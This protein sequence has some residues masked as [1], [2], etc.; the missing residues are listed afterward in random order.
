[1]KFGDAKICYTAIFRNEEKNVY[2]CLDAL[3]DMIDFVCITD[4]GSEDDT[5]KLIQ[6]WGRENDKPTKVFK[7]TFKNFGYNRSRSFTNAKK[8]FPQ[9]DYCLLI[10]AD[11]VLV[12]EDGWKD[13]EL[14]H[15]KYHFNQK[16]KLLVY[17][18]IRYWDHKYNAALQLP[19]SLYSLQRQR[20][21][22]N[23]HT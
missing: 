14:T 17:K 4:T 11:M 7:D 1:M 3:K 10:D 6:K 19:L 9:S 22:E 5:I 18:N 20:I 12:L 2:R 21:S 15:D 23:K 16:N 13:I 8:A